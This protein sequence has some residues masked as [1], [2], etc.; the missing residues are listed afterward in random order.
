MRN[1]PP[2]PMAATTRPP[3]AGPRTAGR[4]GARS[5]PARWPRRGVGRD[6]VG[7]D[8]AERRAEERLARPVEQDER[9]EMPDLERAGGESTPIDD[10]REPRAR[11]R[12]RSSRGGGRSGRS[13]RRP[14]AGTARGRST[15]RGRR[16]PAPPGRFRGRRPATP[17]RRG[18]CRRRAARSSARPQQ[19]EVALAQRLQDLHDALR[20]AAMLVA[21]DGPAGAGKSTVARAV[22]QALGFT[23]LDTGAMYRGVALSGDPTTPR[24][25]AHPLRGD[26]V[27][28][29]GED[30]TDAIRAPEVTEA[31]SRR[32]ADP[33]V[34]AA[35]VDTPAR[36]DRRA[37]TGSP[38][39]ATSAR[40]SRPTPS[41]RSS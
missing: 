28:L 10:Q 27:T 8:R 6:E 23:Y 36:A 21:I 3:I 20:A 35:L 32:A 19:R 13:R 25:L 15:T 39:G 26:R 30:V 37:A 31:A 29:D 4:S 34:R 38:R 18:R 24:A 22:A 17:P 33:A 14:S 16:A 7:N 9:H 40:S 12:P 11:G 1:A 5:A 41:S 2:G